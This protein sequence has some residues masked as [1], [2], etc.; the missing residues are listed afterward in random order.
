MSEVEWDLVT[1]SGPG[2]GWPIVRFT[3]SAA[4]LTTLLMR[5]CSEDVDDVAYF[6]GEFMQ[7]AAADLYFIELDIAFESDDTLEATIERL[8]ASKEASAQTIKITQDML[9]HGKK[10]D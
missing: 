2:G 8:V 3:G 9:G 7:P 1:E 10:Y 4:Q 5:Y 6:K